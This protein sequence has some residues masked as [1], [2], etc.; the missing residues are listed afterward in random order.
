MRLVE[1]RGV[2][3][4]IDAAQGTANKVTIHNRA[5]MGGRRGLEQIE[6]YDI[7]S[8]LP[9][10]LHKACSEVPGASSDEYAHSVTTPCWFRRRLCC[11][12]ALQCLLSEPALP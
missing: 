5:H 11:S 3:D 7:M 12:L 1:R 2:D 4:T 10:S 8:A 9:Q 6:S